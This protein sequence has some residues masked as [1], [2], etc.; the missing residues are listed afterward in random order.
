MPS[1]FLLAGLQKRNGLTAVALV[2]PN[3]S[4][5]STTFGV[6]TAPARVL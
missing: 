3:W 5:R 1:S 2:V 4:T 6:K